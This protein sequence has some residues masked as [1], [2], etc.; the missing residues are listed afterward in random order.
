MSAKPKAAKKPYSVPSIMTLD[1]QAAQAQLKA[2]G[3]PK[4]PNVQKMLSL[5][6]KQLNRRK[7]KSHS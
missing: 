6:D 2:K 7:A 3:D 5:M 4:D 1:A